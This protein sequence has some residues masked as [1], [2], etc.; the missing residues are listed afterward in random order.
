MGKKKKISFKVPDSIKHDEAHKLITGL[1]KQ[2]N[3]K[4][5]LELSDIPQLHRMATAYDMYLSCVD[6]LSKQG[7]TMENLKGE[8]VKRPEANLL[9]ESWSQYLE[10]A[11]EYGLTAKSK[12]QIKAMS[13]GDNEESPLDKFITDRK[14]VR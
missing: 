7:L 6:I 11:K 5:M 12:G 8:M 14:E 3:E 10:L 4:E 9:K 13:A 1:V 2:L